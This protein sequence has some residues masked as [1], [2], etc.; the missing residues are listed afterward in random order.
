MDSLVGTSLGG[1]R[2]TRFLGSGG[3]GAVYLAEDPAIGQQVAIKIVRTDSEDSLDMGA[4]LKAA[5]RFKQEARA[6]ASLD[7][8]HILPLYRY[9]EEQTSGGTRAYMVMQYRPEGSL[10]DWLG[11]GIQHLNNTTGNTTPGMFKAGNGKW[12]LSLQEAGEYL[13]QAASAL[14]YAHERGIIHRDIK[15]ANFLIR[16]D[17][18]NTVH[19][20]LSDFGLAKFYAAVSATSH[21][22]GTPMYMAPEQFEGAA[23][24]ESDQYALAVM[25]YYFLSGH[26]P[27]EGDPM[28]LMHQHLSVP[29][30]PIRTFAP[31]IPEGVET[32]LAHA[33]AKKP[34]QRYPTIAAFAEDFAQK[35]R[36]IPRSYAPQFSLP[37]LRQDSQPAP[38]TPVLPPGNPDRSA[39]QNIP[40]LQQ[41]GDH[42]GSPLHIPGLQQSPLVQGASLAQPEA[43]APTGA[44]AACAPTV[45]H[46]PITPAQLKPVSQLPQVSVPPGPVAPSTAPKVSRR[47]VLGWLIGGAAVVALGGGAG[48]Y[49][50]VHNRKPGQALYVL[51]GHS[52]AVTSI[53]WS[54]DGAQLLS[55]SRDA[56]AKLWAVANEQNTITYSGHQGAVLSVAWSPTG[57]LLASGGEDKTV[58]FWKSDGTTQHTFPNLGAAISSL[59]WTPQGNKLYVGTLGN[60]GHEI[61]VSTGAV[62]ASKSRSKIRSLAISPGGRFLATGLDSGYITIINLQEPL[63]KVQVFPSHTGSI[64]NLAYSADGSML[65]V[66]GSSKTGQILNAATGKVLRSLPH[67][68]PVTGVAWDPANVARLATASADGTVNLW[69]ANSSGRTVY[70]GHTDAA[71]TVAWGAGGLASGSADKNIIVWKV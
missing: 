41:E 45:Y 69:D 53:S 21:I 52:D 65:A 46:T 15:P 12:P 63:A 51:S 55:G 61:F 36:E 50:Y 60:G 68:A 18:G 13:R 40:G 27:F 5:E 42:K 43:A 33:L 16:L 8:L 71:T 14:Q 49:F 17:S 20:L 26:L 4:T 44:N 24:P 35:V 34:S 2:L 30:P 23:V 19:L 10:S 48:I 29:P 57:G 62:K 37:T 39:A 64:N 32:A 7:H 22:L 59:A 38:F 56:T 58:L 3:M 54:P 67:D 9:G 47:G 6:V 1:Y 66:G 28:Q 70:K 31:S 11:R 25:I